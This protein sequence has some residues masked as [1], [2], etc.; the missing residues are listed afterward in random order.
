MQLGGSIASAFGN[1]FK[2]ERAD[3]RI[4]LMAGVAAG[5][6]A[7]FGTPIAGAIFALEV[8]TIGRMQYEA[9]IPCLMAAIAGDWTCHAWESSTLTIPSLT[10]QAAP[11][12]SVFTSMRCCLSK[13][14]SPELRLGLRP[15]S[16]PKS[17]I[18]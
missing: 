1:I 3:I 15:G 13:S 11:R 16:S 6:G 2:L 4:L 18:S 5:F 12:P 8:L 7:V 17:R 9:L 14:A 10:C